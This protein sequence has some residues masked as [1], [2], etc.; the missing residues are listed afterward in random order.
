MPLYLCLPL[1]PNQNAS[2]QQS[3]RKLHSSTQD[4]PL[5]SG[6]ISTSSTIATPPGFHRSTNHHH[7]TQHNGKHHFCHAQH[8]RLSRYGI[9][10]CVY[11]PDAQK[12]TP[13]QRLKYDLPFT[14]S[15]SRRI[16][17]SNC[18][19]LPINLRDANRT[20]NLNLLRTPSSHLL[21]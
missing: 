7:A 1:P 14:T 21:A 2:N 5:L 6:V 17:F 19:S 8:H 18:R 3:T 12:K 15:L 13:I 9:E 16:N 4:S 10:D 11:S 20:I